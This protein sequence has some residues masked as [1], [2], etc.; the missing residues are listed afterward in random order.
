GAPRRGNTPPPEPADTAAAPANPNALESPKPGDVRQR[1]VE[2]NEE[3]SDRIIAV[4]NNDAITMNELLETIVVY[5]TENRSG[6]PTDE[7]LRKEA[8]SRLLDHRLALH[9]ARR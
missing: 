6:G 7:D 3:I 9:E 4:V 8:L 5:R 1:P 2:H